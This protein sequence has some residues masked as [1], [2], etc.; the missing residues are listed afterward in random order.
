MMFRSLFF[1]PIFSLFLSAC[2]FQTDLKIDDTDLPVNFVTQGS[3]P[4]IKNWW[5]AFDNSELDSLIENALT[6]NLSLQADALRLKSSRFEVAIASA[7][8]YPFVNLNGS[9][10][11]DVERPFN[12]NS[13]VLSLSASWEVDIWGKIKAKEDITQWRFKQQEAIFFARTNTIVANTIQAWLSI[14]TEQR[15][16]QVLSE[17][18]LRIS[19]ALQVISRRFAMGKSSITNIWQQEKLLKS[20]ELKQA[21]STAQLY[22]AKQQL[23]LW[24]G[25]PHTDQIKLSTEHLPSLPL[26]PEMDK[27][28]L[29]LGNRPD[30]VQAYASL[31]EADSNLAVAM[32]DRL[33]RFTLKATA[34]THKNSY[35]DLLDD[36]ASNFIG[37]LTAP[38][39]DAGKRSTKVKQRSLQL[40]ASILDY[41][42]TWLDA[43]AAV[44]K[45]L[46]N[47]Q[48]LI[49]AV[50]NLELQL[51]LAQK[52]EKLIQVRYLN[53]KTRFINLLDAQEDI[54]ALENQLIDANKAVLLNRVILYRELSHGQFS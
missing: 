12:V 51:S 33:P 22:I 3:N 49:A 9:T 53:S 21:K 36:W 15:K 42:Q 6:H 46:V 14:L 5:Q 48:Q 11:S 38:I 10:N 24:L 20:I 40:N 30:I 32:A 27:P 16:Q 19:A 26:I 35:Q 18:H 44:N 23:A 2:S 7:E 43:I 31:Q 54:L 25:E 50:N 52:S 4:L 37:G 1:L 29:Q 47:E 17:Q 41:K 45:A 8:Q 39:F 13:A 34:S 28:L